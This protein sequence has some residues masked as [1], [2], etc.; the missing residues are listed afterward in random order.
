M[1]NRFQIIGASEVAGLL[2]E[3]A[4]NLLAENIIN[5]EQFNKIS[6]M[7]SY[8]ETRYSL[9]KKLEMNEVY[10]EK[11]SKSMQNEAMQR[12]KD[13]EQMVAEDYLATTNVKIVEEQTSVDDL[14]TGTIFPFRATIDYI[15]DNGKILEIKTTAISQWEFNCGDDDSY[16]MPYNYYIQVQAQMWMHKKEEAIIYIAGI[17]TVKNGKDKSYNILQTKSFELKKDNAIIKAIKTSLIWFSYEFKKGVL[18]NKAEENKTAKDKQIDEFLIHEADTVDIEPNDNLTYKIARLKEIEAFVKEY[19]KLEK[20]IKE[21]IKA[22]MQ[23]LQKG[24]ARI[25]HNSYN[26]EAK[27]SKTSFHTEETITSAI[28]KVKKLNVGDVSSPA[29]FLLTIKN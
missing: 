26:V 13:C 11:Y 6:K 3:Y 15:L 4:G 25:S 29:K 5:E 20:E 1:K 9:A 14:I 23:N 7:P 18:F 22:T 28:E 2:K 17:E 10:F 12:G 21:E 8:L 24:R 16:R 27:F 19:E